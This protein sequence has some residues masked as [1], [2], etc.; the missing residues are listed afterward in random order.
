ML[1]IG[2]FTSQERKRVFGQSGDFI[3]KKHYQV[4]FIQQGVQHVVLLRPPQEDFLQRAVRMFRNRDPL[5]PSSLT[6]KQ[7][8]AI[9]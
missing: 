9:R 4:E 3:F 6:D 1:G 8:Q 7:L 5:A 2:H